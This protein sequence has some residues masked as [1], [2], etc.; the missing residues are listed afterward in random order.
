MHVRGRTEGRYVDVH[1]HLGQTWNSR[2]ALAAEAAL[3]LDGCSISIATGNCASAYLARVVELSFDERFRARLKRQPHRDR[4]DSLLLGRSSG[5]VFKGGREGLVGMLQA[6]CRRRGQG[7][8]RTQ[9][10]RAPQRSS[11]LVD[12]RSL[13]RGRTADPVSS[14]QPTQHRQAGIAGARRRAE[15]RAGNDFHRAR[16][17]LVGLYFRPD[18]ARPT[19]EAIRKAPSRLE[20]AIDRLMESYPEHLR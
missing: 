11:Q 5:L 6:I 1:T 3:A 15:G 12:L 16:A 18:Q 2:P 19:W 7:V 20:G 9:A 8:W 10:G 14:R 4:L 13:W 17:G